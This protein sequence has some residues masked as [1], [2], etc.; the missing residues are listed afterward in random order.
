MILGAPPAQNPTWRLMQVRPPNTSLFRS[1]QMV[2]GAAAYQAALVAS[3]RLKGTQAEVFALLDERRRQ[4]FF[5]DAAKSAWTYEDIVS[6]QLGTRFFFQHGTK[7]N[8]MSAAAREPSMLA[9]LTS[10]FTEIGVVDDQDALDKQAKA[11]GLP[12]KE[13]YEAGKTTEAR[14][15][16]AHPDSVHAAQ[17]GEVSV[18]DRTVRLPEARRPEPA[19]PAAH[20]TP[21]CAPASS[22]RSATTSRACGS[23]PDDGAARS[24]RAEGAAAYTVGDQL[25]FGAGASPRHAG[26]RPLLV[27]ELAHVVQQ[28]AGRDAPAPTPHAPSARPTPPHAA[29]DPASP[30]DRSPSTGSPPRR[31]PLRRSPPPGSPGPSSPSGSRTWSATT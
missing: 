14:E 17:G 24:A 8:R 25:V 19:S 21:P 11:D 7:I 5:L 1:P 6:D 12:L 16:K 26:R 2:A 23:T 13:A 9:A 28:R 20:S 27:H 30:G 22:A 31:S 29:T 4:K 15:R 3:A 18:R 10:F